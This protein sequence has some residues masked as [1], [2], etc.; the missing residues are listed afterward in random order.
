[1]NTGICLE[2]M[3]KGLEAEIEKMRKSYETLKIQYNT[4]IVRINDL[5]PKCGQKRKRWQAFSED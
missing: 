2:I 4:N 3:I 1:M 5:T